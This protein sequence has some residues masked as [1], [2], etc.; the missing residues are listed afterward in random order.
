MSSKENLPQIHPTDNIS[1]DHVIDAKAKLQNGGLA[2]HLIHMKHSV[3]LDDV[4]NAKG[5]YPAKTNLIELRDVS[6]VIL[7]QYV[8]KR[9]AKEAE[10]TTSQRRI[11][12]LDMD[13]EQGTLNI[14]DHTFE[15]DDD[16]S[17]VSSPI[18]NADLVESPE[19]DRITLASDQIG[20]SKSDE[21]ISEAKNCAAKFISTNKY[22]DH[23]TTDISK[24]DLQDI[25]SGQ[26]IAS[27]AYQT[28][29]GAV[30]GNNVYFDNILDQV[31][32][33][34]TCRTV[35]VKKDDLKGSRHLRS[36]PQPDTEG[37]L[38]HYKFYGC[39]TPYG[40]KCQPSIYGFR[41]PLHVWDDNEGKYTLVYNDRV[42]VNLADCK[43]IN[44]SD[45]VHQKYQP[46]TFCQH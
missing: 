19:E 24:G 7:G 28:D 34:N 1:P 45:C 13:F 8:V 41:G 26:I 35:D 46:L 29:K 16:F 21:N 14:Y 36:F 27:N 3:G 23:S 9:K 37:T 43:E 44:D 32:K 42:T 33:Q 38:Q 18:R 6:S 12:T 10:G 25:G 30:D 39:F 22:N 2:D 4:D 20:D 15:V 17:P 31:A 11:S 40:A 5:K